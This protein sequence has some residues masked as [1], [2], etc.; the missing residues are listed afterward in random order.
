MNMSPM[1]LSVNTQNSAALGPSSLLCP[2]DSQATQIDE[3]EDEKEEEDP[4]AT[5]DQEGNSVPADSQTHL[6]LK[7]DVTKNCGKRPGAE[8]SLQS[9]NSTMNAE[10]VN[11]RGRESG[12]TPSPLPRS[13]SSNLTG[14]SCVEETPLSSAP[15][16]SASQSMICQASTSVTKTGG[17]YQTVSEPVDEEMEEENGGRGDVEKGAQEKEEEEKG[18]LEEEK[19]G[20]EEEGQEGQE[21]EKH[22]QEQSQEK[23]ENAQKESTEGGETPGLALVLSQSQ[24][25]SQEPME[26][27][28]EDGGVD[29]VVMLAHSE[30][31][32]QLSQKDDRRRIK[33]NSS[34][35]THSPHAANGHESQMEEKMDISDGLSQSR[36]VQLEPEGLKDKSLS[37][38]SGGTCTSRSQIC[39]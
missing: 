1:Q 32:S 24:L 12:V 33:T 5:E 35:P 3:E 34:Q 11:V 23:E 29:S 2:D 20:L 19:G 25:L 31:E 26:E 30:G 39:A 9:P 21:E 14:N 16:S 38:S 10:K 36:R 6:S 7:S 22:S 15:C 17:P 18:D 28:G 13:G 37:D 4:S 8:A 27:G